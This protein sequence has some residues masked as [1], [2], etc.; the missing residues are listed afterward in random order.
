MSGW[1]EGG[2]FYSDQGAGAEEDETLM[3]K[4]LA[5]RKFVDFLKNFREVS[6][7]GPTKYLN[8]L[9]C[10]PAP[11]SL[12]VSMDDIKAHSEDLHETLRVNPA[13]YLP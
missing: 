13:E 10:E 12:K 11:R 3:T 5:Q 7:D 2:V 6:A 4:H 9:D 1:D 8:Q